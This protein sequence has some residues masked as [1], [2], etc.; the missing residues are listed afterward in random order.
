MI[1]SSGNFLISL[2]L[3]N[4]LRREK[5]ADLNFL[6]PQAASFLM[7]NIFLSAGQMF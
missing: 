7:N 2:K 1:D 3:R 4:G 6:I 5:R